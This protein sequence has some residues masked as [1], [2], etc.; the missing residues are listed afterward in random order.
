M[1][2]LEVYGSY[3]FNEQILNTFKR[4]PDPRKGTY[5][6]VIRGP[7]IPQSLIVQ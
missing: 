7:A 4:I 3:E 1:L 5:R 6:H 2:L